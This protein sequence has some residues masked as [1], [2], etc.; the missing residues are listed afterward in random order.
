M[1]TCTR[2][3]STHGTSSFRVDI[4]TTCRL[5]YVVVAWPYYYTTCRV[6]CCRYYCCTI[7]MYTVPGTYQHVV[8][9]YFAERIYTSHTY[10]SVL[11]PVCQ[12]GRKRKDR[13]MLISKQQRPL[14]F[15]P[16]RYVY[17][18]FNLPQTERSLVYIRT[19]YILRV[20]RY[21][22]HLLYTRHSQPALF[23]SAATIVLIRTVVRT[24]I[25]YHSARTPYI[26]MVQTIIHAFE[27]RV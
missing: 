9:I 24:I 10:S 19:Y 5:L 20:F 4:D 21:V 12:S 2:Y 23:V 6:C 17:D 15:C 14:H 27:V 11:V 7:C 3:R 16:N 8:Y 25:A 18:T 22:A 1:K 13:E 26:H